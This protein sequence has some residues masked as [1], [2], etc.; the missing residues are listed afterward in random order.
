MHSW[1]EFIKSEK[2]QPYFNRIIDFVLE[3]AK[4]HTIYPPHQEVFAAFN[5]CPLDQVKIVILGQDP[6]HGGQAHG[7]AFSVL[8]GTN[9]PPS[10]SNIYAELQDDLGFVPPKH[11]YLM[12]WEKQ[13]VLLLNAA[14]TV[15]QHQA[16][17]H[18]EIGWRTFTDNAIRLL[19]EQDRP[20]VYLLWG[21]Y[22]RSKQGLLNN[23]K[24]LVLKAPHPSPLSAYKG[25]FG[26]KHFSRA[27]EF[28]IANGADPI[29]W[30]L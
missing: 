28:L 12:P 3:D 27:N 24:H 15:R 10:L 14:L 30:S 7:L 6:Y 5:H 11:G 2:G 26:C 18:Q 17:S 9:I 1:P 13:G 16:G 22:A 19:N 29:D 20:I 23:P 8:P 25:F 21:S 4:T